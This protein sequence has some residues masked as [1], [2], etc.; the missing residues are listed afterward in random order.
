MTV[1]SQTPPGANRT[2]APAALSALF[3]LKVKATPK[4]L[5][6][7]DNPF[8]VNPGKYKGGSTPEIIRNK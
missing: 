1:L 6:T 3:K 7:Y 5:T 8:P 2:L 4:L